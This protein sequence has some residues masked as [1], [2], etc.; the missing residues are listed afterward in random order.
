MLDFA[1]DMIIGGGM[2]FIFH[3]VLNKIKIGSSIYNDNIAGMVPSI[4]KKA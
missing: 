3:S 1:D 2:A 4:M